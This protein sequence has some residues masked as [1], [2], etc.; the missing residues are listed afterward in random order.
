[1]R[2]LT[3][4][5]NDVRLGLLFP[6]EMNDGHDAVGDHVGSVSVIVCADQENDNLWKNKQK[7]RKKNK[8][9]TGNKDLRSWRSA[10]LEQMVP[11]RHPLPTFFEQHIEKLRVARA[12]YTQRHGI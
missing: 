7:K 11:I 3:H 2:R 8:R 1:M 12:T 9:Q 6:D 5:D 10:G 4:H